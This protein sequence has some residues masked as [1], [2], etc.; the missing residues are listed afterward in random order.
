M[1]PQRDWYTTDYYKVLG[2]SETAPDKELRRAYRKLAK[3]YHP[4]SNPGSEERFKAVSAA[5][6]V[7][8]DP[9]KRKEYDEVRRLGPLSNLGGFGGGGGAGGASNGN[10]NFRI[11]DLSD[12][13]GGLFGRG[14][15][16]AGGRGA[17]GTGTGPR[18]GRDL[19]A[20][21]HLS[22]QEAVDGAV[23]TVNV[24]SGTRCS[25][26]GGSGSRP[27]SSPVMC[28]RCGGLGVLNDNQGMFSLSSPCPECQGRGT[29]I[30]DPCPMCNGTGLEQRQRQVKVRI[31]AGVEDGQRI[32]V[33]G[34]GEPGANG[35]P[36]GDLFVIVHVATHPLFGRKGRNLTLTVPITYPEATLGSAITV[37][38]LRDP[39][40]LKIPAGTR[41]GRTFRVKGHGIPSGAS[42]GDL[43]VTVDVVVPAHL[44][45]EQ[46]KAVEALAR[47]LGESPRQHLGV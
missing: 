14:R 39:V 31:P 47:T 17:P 10:F 32:R 40:T 1:A 27:G 38:S 35:G 30:V 36:A 4:D 11:D 24:T 3:Q 34:R 26:C 41:Q 6:D 22:F 43:L 12:I 37:P 21:L 13:F 7:L 8:G 23:T 9:E 19:E 20:E 15:Q 5:Y 45:E 29:K 42:A 28:P 2:V 33:K 44:N 18:R 46:R 25:T 16:H